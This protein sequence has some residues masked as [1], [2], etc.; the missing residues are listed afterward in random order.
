MLFS[1]TL[2]VQIFF[3]L[4]S[5]FLKILPF[6]LFYRRNRQVFGI[7]EIDEYVDENDKAYKIPA[8]GEVQVSHGGYFYSY[9]LFRYDA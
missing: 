5:I 8:V 4:S 6:L 7:Y 2:I 1:T 3:I 9:L